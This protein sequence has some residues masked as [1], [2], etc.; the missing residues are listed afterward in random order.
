MA[1]LFISGPAANSMQ[2]AYSPIQIVAEDDGTSGTGGVP[3][4]VYC[5]IYFNGTYYKTLSSTSAALIS[6]VVSFWT[7]DVSG[8]CR[9]FLSTRIPDIT[10]NDLQVVYIPGISGQVDGG[11]TIFVRVRNSTQDSFG[12]ITPGGTPPVQA[13]FDTP[14][15][16]GSG[17]LGNTFFVVNAALQVTDS[18]SLQD[19]LN[20]FRTKG[21]F[22]TI[23]SVNASYL[24]YQL[25][26]LTKGHVFKNDYGLMPLITGPN[27]FLGGSSVLASIGVKGY[28][29][30]GGTVYEDFTS[31]SFGMNSQS[32]YYM[33]IGLVNLMQLLPSLTPS[34]AASIAYYRVGV[35]DSAGAP[36]VWMYVTPK[37][38]I[39]ANDGVMQG[40]YP[41]TPV[42]APKHTRIYFQNYLGHFDMVNFIEREEKTKVSSSPTEM[43]VVAVP[44][45][46]NR[47]QTSM[48]RN[49]VRSNDYSTITGLFNES[50]MPFLKQLIASTK[51]Y[52][53]FLSPEG[54]G[55]PPVAL[56][57]PIVILDDEFDTL[58]F[59][60][61]YEYAL[62][63]KYMQSNEN[64]VVR[65]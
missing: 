4:I 17:Y 40:Y 6:G 22:D 2:P 63:I 21:V 36:L 37:I 55:D 13:T 7:F 29:S 8:V 44:N 60:E 30:T 16:A 62:T 10:E 64:K 61:R 24:V 41:M 34:V 5:D 28:S 58:T 53:E 65:N 51:T 52:I 59:D 1:I 50:D 15:T 35:R 43:P 11:S 23:E 49:N 14:A 26:Y 57:L 46:F 33:P 3:P 19:V 38:Y 56:M 42:A 25:S 18:N 32:I 12:V 31:P 27:A 47:S 20:S 45:G 9:E 54:I 39:L 48:S